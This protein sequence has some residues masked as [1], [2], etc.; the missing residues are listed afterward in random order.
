MIFSNVSECLRRR[1]H[2]V[3]MLAQVTENPVRVLLMGEALV[4]VRLDGQPRVF[5]DVCPHR[6]AR[7]SNGCVV[8]GQLQCPYHGWQYDSD[9][10]CVHIPALGANAV[11]PPKAR[12]DAVSTMVRYDMVWAVLDDGGPSAALLEIAEF[13]DPALANVW[14]SPRAMRGGAA[15]YIDNFLDFAHFP[16]VHSGTFGLGESPYLDDYS[17]QRRSAGLHVEYHHTIAN[18]EDPL[19]ASG[20]HP[21]VQPRIMTYDCVAPFS[22]NLRLELPTAGMTNSIAV[23]VRP[24]TEHTSV[25]YCVMMRDDCWATDGTIESGKAHAAIDYEFDIVSED[26]S[27]IE[28]LPSASI[29]IDLAANVHTRVDRITV[30]YRRLLAQLIN[31]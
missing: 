22:A 7:L 16:F 18:K 26:F 8:D 6:N 3:A 5:R 29:S 19:V 4:V 14:M 31:T 27:I 24:E 28:N 11:V 25:V 21:L 17:V 12:L 13:D 20:E 10:V 30:E 15:Q 1:W 2:P 23:F 9:G